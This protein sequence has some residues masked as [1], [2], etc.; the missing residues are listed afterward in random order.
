MLERQGLAKSFLT[1]KVEAL[2]E[3]DD[4]DLD[5]LARYLTHTTIPAG[6]EFDVRW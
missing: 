5:D 2:R 6:T 4:D 1:L 3:C